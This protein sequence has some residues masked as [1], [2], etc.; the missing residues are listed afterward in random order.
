MHSGTCLTRAL[1]WSLAAGALMI[2]SAPLP[3]Q[4][5]KPLD[6]KAPRLANGKVNLS[7]PAP[8]LADG[9]VDVSGIWMVDDTHLQFNMMLDGPTIP[10]TP[11]FDA[12]YKRH[13]A[14]E[15]KD[16]PAGKCLPHSIPDGMIVP[17][18]FKIFHAPGTTFILFEEFAQFRQVFTDGRALPKDAEPG[19][20]GYSIGRWE[21]DAFVIETRGFNDKSWLD[22]DGHPHSDALHTIERFRRPDY[23]HMT[24]E[25]TIDDPKAY[26]KTWSATFHEH[27]I[28]DYELIENIC[29]NEQDQKHMPAN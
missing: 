3:A 24:L 7:G 25:L 6:P 2:L 1:R 18:P 15:G 10:L 22:D 19:W 28:P 21:A 9:K 23:G 5:P 26:T 16:R 27:L 29:D 14:T 11:A 12:I 4:W 17:S 20:F 8:K 13:I